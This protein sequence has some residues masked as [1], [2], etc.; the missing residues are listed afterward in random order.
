MNQAPYAMLYHDTSCQTLNEGI[1]KLHSIPNPVFWYQHTVYADNIHS[2]LSYASY[3][4]HDVANQIITL[5]FPKECKWIA[6][7]RNNHNCT[8]IMYYKDIQSYLNNITH[9]KEV[10]IQPNMNIDTRAQNEVAIRI[11]T[12]GNKNLEIYFDMY[13]VKPVKSKL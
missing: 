9:L 8:M 1:R 2:D 4:T 10:T 3:I 6:N 13:L 7:I 5:R 11:H 12:R